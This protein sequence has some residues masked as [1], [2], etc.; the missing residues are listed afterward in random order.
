MGKNVDKALLSLLKEEA[1]EPKME[2]TNSIPAEIT[3]GLEI[4][5]ENN[6]NASLASTSAVADLPEEE[7]G[8]IKS[9][10]IELGTSLKSALENINWKEIDLETMPKLWYQGTDG[11]NLLS[12]TDTSVLEQYVQEVITW[13]EEQPKGEEQYSDEESDDEEN[14]VKYEE[15]VGFASGRKI[16]LMTETSE[17]ALEDFNNYPIEVLEEYSLSKGFEFVSKEKTLS[18]L[19]ETGRVTKKDLNKFYEEYRINKINKVLLESPENDLG[20]PED[21]DFRNTNHM[22]KFTENDPEYDL[23]TA[24]SGEGWESYVESHRNAGVEIT[25]DSVNDAFLVSPYVEEL[26]ESERY[27][28]PQEDKEIVESVIIGKKYKLVECR[29]ALKSSKKENIMEVI[30]EKDGHKTTIQYDDAAIIKPWRIGYNEFNLLQEALNAIHIPFKKLV[31]DTIE[32]NKK[33]SKAP[34]ILEKIQRQ[35]YNKTQ[36]LP[37]SEEERR[38][39]RGEEITRQIFGEV[40]DKS[41]LKEN[42]YTDF[43]VNYGSEIRIALL[44][45]N[46]VAKAVEINSISRE[47]F[48]KAYD[49][50]EGIYDGPVVSFI[51]DAITNK[52]SATAEDMASVG[53][54]I[55]NRYGTEPRM[56]IY[57]IDDFCSRLNLEDDEDE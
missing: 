3:N 2:E 34:M 15:S 16:K 19:L 39:M 40:E 55:Q 21:L 35:Y 8:E 27:E 6:I 50:I 24:M 41:V 11:W 38:L 23:L 43:L 4:W 54:Q 45:L 13:A 18:R 37:R 49:Y 32:A 51:E 12:Q 9:K 7:V 44:E 31:N 56:V 53:L 26:E 57:A 47:S 14:P 52:R 10:V 1:E 28:I 20:Y 30:V 22:I 36:N 17:F 33:V 5:D 42:T 46:K 29:G 25:Y 48:D